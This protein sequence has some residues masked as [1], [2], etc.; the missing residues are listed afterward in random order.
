M[1]ALSKLE[2]TL[3]AAICLTVYGLVN[4]WVPYYDDTKPVKTFCRAAK[5][6]HVFTVFGASSHKKRIW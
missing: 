4:L 1:S 3:I 6:P 5:K 2:M